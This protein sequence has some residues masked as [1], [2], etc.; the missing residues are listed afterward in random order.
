[1]LKHITILSHTLEGISHG[2]QAEASTR[3]EE[4]EERRKATASRMRSLLSLSHEA[5]TGLGATCGTGTLAPLSAG[6]LA[7]A[8]QKA[9]W[10]EGHA[11]KEWEPQHHWP[12]PLPGALKIPWGYNGKD[13]TLA[14]AGGYSGRVQEDRGSQTF[15]GSSE[16]TWGGHGQ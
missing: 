12:V 10:G 9:V 11:C 13:W 15:D 5:R 4:H 14:A 7:I 2:L 8:V 1:V 16:G 6:E 3:R